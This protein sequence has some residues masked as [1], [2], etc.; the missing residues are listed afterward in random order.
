[1]GRGRAARHLPPTPRAGPR[2]RG[3]RRGGRHADGGHAARLL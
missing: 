1:A 2:R 3:P